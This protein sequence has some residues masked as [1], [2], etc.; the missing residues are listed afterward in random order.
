MKIIAL[1][2]IAAGKLILTPC[3]VKISSRK[4]S[5]PAPKR[6]VDLG[7]VPLPCGGVEEND[8]DTTSF[9]IVHQFKAPA[10]DADAKHGSWVA[11]F[12]LVP[13]HDEDPNMWI[14]NKIVT[15]DLPNGYSHKVAIPC[16][17]NA[18]M[19]QKGDVITRPTR[20]QQTTA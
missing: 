2:R 4:S 13:E 1:K 15:L 16:L 18:A 8:D 6:A 14:T 12:W 9:H 11:A 10:D 17:T 19:I 20:A 3:N 7:H 5:E